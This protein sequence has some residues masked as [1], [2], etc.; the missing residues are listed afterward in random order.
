VYACSLSLELWAG[1]GL[2]LRKSHLS[3]ELNWGEVFAVDDE[4]EG[5]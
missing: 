3:G 2:I 1:L 4:A 5:S